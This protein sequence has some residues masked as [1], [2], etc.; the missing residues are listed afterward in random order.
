MIDRYVT[1]LSRTLRG[2][3][4]AKADLLAEARDGLIDAADAYEDS[5]LNR[6]SAERQAVADFGPVHVVAPDY[7]AELG[8][9]QGRRTA[10]LI[11][12]VMLTQPVAWRV[13]QTLTKDAPGG[14]GGRGYELVDAA[15]RWS[16]GITI[17]LGLA[18]LFATGTGVRRLGSPRLVA[19]VTGIFAFTVCAVF[20]VLGLLLTLSDP[21]T[22][23]PLS[24]TGLPST[25]VVLG[26]PLAGIGVAGRR[27][28]SAA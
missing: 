26:I 9:A 24:P 22:H 18:V 28:L 23:S 17:A 10:I 27:C 4:T 8:L 13:M 14:H 11:C 1:E 20:A 7:Q 19:R 2:P 16:G 3:R 21:A 5:G 12:A 15:A 25:L 6:E